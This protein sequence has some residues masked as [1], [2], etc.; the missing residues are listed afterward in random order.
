M[1]TQAGAWIDRERK[2]QVNHRAAVKWV[3][4]DTNVHTVIPGFTNVEQMNMHLSV[5]NDLELTPEEQADL[6]SAFAEEG[7][8]CQQCGGCGTQCRHSLDIPS[9]MRA[10]MYAYGYRDPGRAKE[11]ISHIKPGGIL[12]VRCPVSCEMGFDIRARFIDIARVRT[13]PDD[14]LT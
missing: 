7:L 8:Y 12:C 11:T 5:M 2:V 1:K 4:N 14:F 13:V 10:Y 9:L 3:L 6:A